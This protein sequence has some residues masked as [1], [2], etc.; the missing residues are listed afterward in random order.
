MIFNLLLMFLILSSCQ[1]VLAEPVENNFGIVNA[2]Y[3]GEEATVENVQLKVGEP[4][5]IKV[6]VT[7]KIDGHVNV[8]LVN[9]LVTESFEVVSGPSIIDERIDNLNIKSGW[10]ETYIWVIRPTGKWTNGNAP[11]NLFI[12]FTKAHDEYEHTKFTIANPYIL[13]EQHS[14]PAPTRTADPSSTDQTPTQG[15]PGFGVM[16]A[17]TGIVLVMIT[18]RG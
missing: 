10:S 11:I 12:Q 15:S 16:G 6:E 7:S 1:I 2:W 17:L 3:N 9:P 5:E 18:R 8:K 13:D 4:V 14:G